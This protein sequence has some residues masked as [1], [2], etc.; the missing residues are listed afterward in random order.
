ML[1]IQNSL[2]FLSVFLSALI[3][4][5]LYGYACSVNPGLNKL[6]DSEYLRAMQSINKE[7]LNPF[8]FI[9]FMGT[10]MILPVTTWYSKSHATLTCF[11][12]LLA[13]SIIYIIG[14]VGVTAFGNIPLNNALA[15]FNILS[16]TSSDLSK[17]RSLFE[18]SW[19]RYH[20]IRTLFSV[21]TTAL[22]I[23]A[24]IKNG[25]VNTSYP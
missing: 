5:L 24:I 22:T 23:T 16:A 12:L 21:L 15:K 4:G 1:T 14:V 25:D 13:A 8:F 3:M 17:Q 6:T 7:I 11:Y 9:S 18:A 20:L 10:L 19:N 2:L